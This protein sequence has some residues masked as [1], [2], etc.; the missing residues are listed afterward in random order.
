M[1]MGQDVLR[2]K[3]RNYAQHSSKQVF[4]ANSFEKIISNM[5]LPTFFAELDFVN[6]QDIEEYW[7]R[8]AILSKPTKSGMDGAN[9]GI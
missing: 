7:D 6:A 3:L 8:V 4:L 9:G 2:V 1:S 5:T